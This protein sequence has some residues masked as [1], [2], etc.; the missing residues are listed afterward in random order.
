MKLAYSFTAIALSIFLIGCPQKAL[1]FTEQPEDQVVVEGYDAVFSALAEYL[2]VEDNKLNPPIEYKWF[3]LPTGATT[4]N[5]TAWEKGRTNFIVQD[6]TPEDEGEIWV[7]ARRRDEI[8]RSK[9][10]TLTLYRVDLGG[11]RIF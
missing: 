6:M 11:L 5:E 1:E 7:D 4:P 3:H 9:V 2:E 8:V 10:V